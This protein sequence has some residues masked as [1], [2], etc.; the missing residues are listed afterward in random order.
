M[1]GPKLNAHCRMLERSESS[2]WNVERLDPKT[3]MTAEPFA[4]TEVTF[5]G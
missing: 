4:G 2:E 5:Y 3:T 1:T